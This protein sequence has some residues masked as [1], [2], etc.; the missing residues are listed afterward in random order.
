MDRFRW[1]GFSLTELIIVLAIV[2]I[3]AASVTM[4]WP[5]FGDRAER[6]GWL[7]N[8]HTVQQAV[9]QYY[10]ERGSYPTLGGQPSLGDPKVIDWNQ[11]VPSYLRSRPGDADRRYYWV[12]VYGKV[13]SAPFDAPTGFAVNADG[14]ASWNAVTGAEG[15]VI[16]Q[17]T[18]TSW[19]GYLLAARLPGLV[20][21]RSVPAGSLTVQNGVVTYSP[22]PPLSQSATYFISALA[23]A[24]ETPPVGKTYSGIRTYGSDLRSGLA[25]WEPGYDDSA[26][27]LATPIVL[28]G[29]Q[30]WGPGR[31]YQLSEEQVYIGI[32]VPYWTPLTQY[33]ATWSPGAGRTI[34]RV[35]WGGDIAAWNEARL[36]GM[37]SSGS[38]L[39]EVIKRGYSVWS[40]WA[41]FPEGT[42]SL[43][44]SIKYSDGNA[45]V[46]N[47][48]VWVKRY[49]CPWNTASC[50]SD[51][52]ALWI[53]DRD[54][55]SGAP[56]GDTYFRKRFTVASLTTARLVVR[57]DDMAEIY[58]DGQKLNVSPSASQ[59]SEIQV[60][61]SPGEHVIAA[62]ATNTSGPAG[63]VL[64]LVDGNGATI[65]HTDGTWKVLGYQEQ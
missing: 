37:D 23:R 65:V 55:R 47:G 62:K 35:S 49:I 63:L 53:W 3:L 18:S 14:T 64:T 13:Y 60:S 28:V 32:R 56:T 39:K 61:L 26:W 30:P 48:Y 21:V 50:P 36:V 15:Y 4:A 2:A 42:T 6:S 1:R 7:A 34:S 45:E 16:W 22:S 38:A 11:L 51:D 46:G 54:S 41:S 29:E 27:T 24:G 12:D 31:G 20:R 40:E 43:R 33:V 19:A 52:S 17:Q 5:V 44:L 59:A 57:A 58:L 8:L 25:W 9:D 10:L